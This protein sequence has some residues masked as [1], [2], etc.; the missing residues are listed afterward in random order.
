MKT[1]LSSKNFLSNNWAKNSNSIWLASSM[2]LYR[3]LKTHNFPHKLE[4]SFLSELTHMLKHPLENCS[5]LK[6]GHFFLMKDLKPDERQLLFEYYLAGH[7]YQ[8]FHGQEGLFIDSTHNLHVLINTSDHL[9]LNYVNSS[10]HLEDIFS[11]LIH[12]ENELTKEIEFAFSPK[13]G[14]LTSSIDDCGTGLNVDIFLHLP[15]L[16]HMKKI[17]EQL[18]KNASHSIFYTSIQG[19]SDVF[20]GDLVVLS[21]QQT[22]GVSEEQLIK[23]VHS[24]ALNLII[25]EKKARESLK[26]EPSNLKNNVSKAFGTLKHAYQLDEEEAMHC[27]SLCKLGVELE[28][29]QNLSVEKINELFFSMGK[30]SLQLRVSSSEDLPSQRATLIKKEIEKASL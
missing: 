21:N 9:V 20:L 4:S 12:M 28:W 8:S 27:L 15:A 1:L 18:E 25:A 3:N 30:S 19:Q 23:S 26:K 13:F 2:R 24:H 22:L 16:I 6:K 14:F 7:N 5:Q 17:D 29:I 11:K 10:N